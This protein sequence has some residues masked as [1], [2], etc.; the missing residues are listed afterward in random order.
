MKQLENIDLEKCSDT[1]IANF[2]KK[3]FSKGTLKKANELRNNLNNSFNSFAFQNETS[4]KENKNFTKDDL[5]VGTKLKL[6]NFSEIA[7][8]TSLSGKQNQLQVQIGSIKM[9]VKLT[10]IENILNEKIDNNIAIP[11]NKNSFTSFKS[12]NIS[13]EINVIGQNIEDACFIID[14]YLD[15]CSIAKFSPI[16]IVHGKGSGKL[17]EGIHTFLRKNPHVK[18]FRLGTFGEG[19][20]GVTVVELK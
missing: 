2:V 5:K 4:K 11:S 12:K 9:N 18:S 19:E 20:M 10:D 6:N 14:K 17:R 15:D 7:S 13:P 1:E 16:R 3:Y 8:I